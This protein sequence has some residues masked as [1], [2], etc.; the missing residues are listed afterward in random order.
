MWTLAFNNITNVLRV[1]QGRSQAPKCI[2]LTA[3]VLRSRRAVLHCRN[4]T[5]QDLHSVLL[6]AHVPGQTAS[7]HHQNS[8]GGL[9]WLRHCLLLRNPF[10]VLA[11]PIFMGT[12]AWRIR[13][14]L[15]R[16]SCAELGACRHQYPSR[17]D[18]IDAAV[19]TTIRLGSVHEEEDKCHADVSCGNLVSVQSKQI[20]NQTD[21]S[22]VEPSSQLSD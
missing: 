3:T 4:G 16:L 10:P 22:L 6:S 1:S 5:C 18:H 7:D 13:R 19:E 12:V 9:H 21:L 15:Q 14:H 8:Y 11:Y 2:I 17:S 20:G